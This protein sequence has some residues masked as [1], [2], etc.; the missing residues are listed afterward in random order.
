MLI[1]IHGADTFSS[2]QYLEAV[3]NQFNQKHD[4]SGRAVYFFTEESGSW[5]DLARQLTASGLFIQKRLIVAKDVLSRKDIA[6][7]LGDFFE[8]SS[9][10][11]DITLVVYQSVEV[12]KRLRLTKKLSAGKLSREFE[13]PKPFAVERFIKER[14][15]ACGKTIEPAAARLLAEIV[16]ADLW[17]A[18]AEVDKSVCLP[19]QTIS[20]SDIKQTAASSP[21]DEIWPLLDA[22]AG[23]KKNQALQ[24]LERQL[25]AGAEPTYLLSMV[26]RQVRLILAVHNAPESES[27][28]AAGLSI[29]PYAIKKAREHAG[30]FTIAK[31]KLMYQAILR[32]DAALKSGRGEPAALFTVLLDSIIK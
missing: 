9:L 19:R 32:L 2:R 14:V 7:G 6:E 12:D 17:R 23:G 28:L 29:H 13:L 15:L 16:G 31:L 22:V 1:F 27:A 11:D 18:Q 10:G 26:V 8:S 20:L 25:T 4:P 3:I 30:N 5:D 21:D 24:L